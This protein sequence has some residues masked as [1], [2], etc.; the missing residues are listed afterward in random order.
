MITTEARR[1]ICGLDVA[2][3]PAGDHLGGIGRS[4]QDLADFL[5]WDREH[6]VQ[7]ERQALALSERIGHD[8]AL[9]TAG[10]T[11]TGE[12]LQDQQF[13]R[14]AVLHR[15]HDPNRGHPTSA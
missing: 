3:S 10:D 1:L 2:T 7:D 11:L 9:T 14:G 4:T 12:W 6:L 5:E 15:R 8:E 13:P